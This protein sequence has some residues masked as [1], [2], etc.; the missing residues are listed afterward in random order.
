MVKEFTVWFV[1]SMDDPDFNIQVT[2]LQMT[3]PDEASGFFGAGYDVIEVKKGV[4]V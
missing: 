4:H 1:D 2:T 3:S